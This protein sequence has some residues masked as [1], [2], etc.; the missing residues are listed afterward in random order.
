MN[1]KQNI[2]MS[3][4][5]LALFSL[6]LL[7]VFGD[8]GLA[9]LNLMK[10]GR[11]GLIEKNAVLKQENISLYRS[12]ERL[13]YDLGFIENVA[14]QDLGLVRKDE[15]IFKNCLSAAFGRRDFSATSAKSEIIRED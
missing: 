4:T 15:L 2:L 1:S 13:K 14:R 12:I 8:K 7:I 3:F 6:L 10:K 9:D 11:D 5:L